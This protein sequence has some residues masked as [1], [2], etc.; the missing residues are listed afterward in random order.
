MSRDT[1]HPLPNPPKKRLGW[2]GKSLLAL[3]LLA[4]LGTGALYVTHLRAKARLAAFKRT[5]V[6]QGV[7]LDI[8]KLIPP[9]PAGTNRIAE[10][11]SAAMG[12]QESPGLPTLMRGVAPGRARV[13]WRQE[14]LMSHQ[15]N[16]CWPDTLQFV[17]DN[18]AAISNLVLALEDSDCLWEAR[19]YQAG[20]AKLP[21]Q[22]PTMGRKV[23]HALMVA[24]AVSLR[25]GRSEESWQRLRALT[26]LAQQQHREEPVLISQLVRWGIQSRSLNATWEALQA[27]GWEDGQWTQLQ[28]HW[29]NMV[30]TNDLILALQME[31]AWGVQLLEECRQQPVMLADA[32]ALNTGAATTPL[33]MV[34]E[35]VEGQQGGFQ[36]F[37]RR[38]VSPWAWP[39]WWSYEDEEYYLKHTR[40]V[41][42][43]AVELNTT[44]FVRVTNSLQQVLSALGEP[45]EMRFLFSHGMIDKE[46]KPLERIAAVRVAAAMTAT[47]IAL[48][49]HH[50]RHGRHP[51]SL[52]ELIPAL[53]PALPRDWM[54][55]GTLRYRREADGGYLLWSV[56]ADGKDDGGDA[57]MPTPPSAGNAHQ[58]LKGRD[59]VWPRPATAEEVDRDNEAIRKKSSWGRR[60]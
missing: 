60:Q 59:I 21:F 51:E 36:G 3:P 16:D 53:L 20:M 52:A 43:A 4:V 57:A 22:H 33:D 6:A 8:A 10:L 37:V 19:N 5:L 38:A 24:A 58:W 7:V 41:A 27:Q 17:A 46:F 42:D 45:S 40:A 11:R 12:L 35:I 1:D 26:V 32:L 31:R 9:A 55:G 18:A 34:K 48:K 39:Y 54:D 47:A 56:G 23:A 2:L 50:L 14:K 29:L 15:A 13:S 25:Q 28:A 49:R 30:S 44:S